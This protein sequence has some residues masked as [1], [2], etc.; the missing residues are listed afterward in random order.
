MRILIICPFTCLCQLPFI[1]LYFG[2]SSTEEVL[3]S[4]SVIAG[5]IVGAPE[6][7]LVLYSILAVLSNTPKLGSG[8]EKAQ[9]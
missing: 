7:F 9:T 3:I 2:V 8:R 1:L 4:S 6:S 5:E